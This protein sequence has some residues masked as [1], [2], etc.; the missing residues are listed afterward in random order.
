MLTQPKCAQLHV[1]LYILVITFDLY[2]L[3]YKVLVVSD[4]ESIG[5]LFP[6][7]GPTMTHEGF[8]K[9]HRLGFLMYLLPQPVGLGSLGYCL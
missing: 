7:I 5:D 3:Y 1:I 2:F 9:L 6:Q 4:L 8:F